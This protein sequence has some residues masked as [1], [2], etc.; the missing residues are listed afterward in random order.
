MVVEQVNTNHVNHRYLPDAELSPGLRATSDLE[1]SLDGA[2]LVLIAV[3]SR[4][5]PDLLESA[6]SLIPVSAVLIHAVKGFVRPSNQRVSEFIVSVLGRV[7][8]R[9]AVLS[10]PS[11]AEEVV[12]GVPTTVVVASQSQSTAELAQDALMNDSLRVYTQSD[13][14]GVELGGTLKN[15]IGLGVGLIDGLGLGDNTRAA[16]MTR[17]LAEMTRLGVALG[18][19]PLTFS[20]L[21]GVGDLIVTCTS[22]HSRNYRAGHLLATGLSLDEVLERVGM[23]VEGVGTTFAASDLAEIHDIELPITRALKSVLGGD[24]SA[25][26]AVQSL[27]RRDKNHEMEDLGQQPFSMH[28]TSP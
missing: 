13:L 22:S 18:A 17:G 9:L 28:W 2:E 14:V 5:L 4:A 7:E 16:L 8:T 3:P 10:G 27:M 21:A 15:I 11:H 1:S 25:K 6:K 20:G 12:R 19:S 26:E 24:V 23:A